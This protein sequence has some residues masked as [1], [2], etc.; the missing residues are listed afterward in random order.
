[1]GGTIQLTGRSNTGDGAVAGFSSGA[2]YD[3]LAFIAIRKTAFFIF[4]R[5]IPVP[6]QLYMNQ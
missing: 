3:S 4:E 2:A 6:C 1:M 5:I